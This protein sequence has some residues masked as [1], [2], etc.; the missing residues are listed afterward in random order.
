MVFWCKTSSWVLMEFW[1]IFMIKFWSN[2]DG[3]FLSSSDG[4]LMDISDQ[5][6]MEFW[7]VFLIEF[8]SSSDGFL[9]I[10]V[11]FHIIKPSKEKYMLSNDHSVICISKK[12]RKWHFCHPSENRKKIWLLISCLQLRIKASIWY[13]EFKK[14]L[15]SIRT[16]RK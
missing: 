5:V 11:V 9:E 6:L 12:V 3:C 4:V 15:W 7:W 13:L 16:V 2:S 8:W 14:T 10:Y 1:W